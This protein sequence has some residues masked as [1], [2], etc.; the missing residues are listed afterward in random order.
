M[1]VGLQ[2]MKYNALWTGVVLSLA[3]I[4]YSTAAEVRTPCFHM[5][6]L[7]HSASVNLADL[8]HVTWH[9][10]VSDTYSW[11]QRRLHQAGLLQQPLSGGGIASNT[12]GSVGLD[13]AKGAATATP[14][15]SSASA[16]G[17]TSAPNAKTRLAAAPAAAP[18]TAKGFITA[19]ASDSELEARAQN[20]KPLSPVTHSWAPTLCLARGVFSRCLPDGDET[21][22]CASSSTPPTSMCQAVQTVILHTSSVASA[23][24]A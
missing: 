1:D 23:C 7:W 12:L 11:A 20:V 21:Q 9:D 22:P 19:A 6:C 15:T 3:L 14:S 5:T 18:E 24:V 17:T 13:Q 8:G 2:T 16:G 4:G 10:W